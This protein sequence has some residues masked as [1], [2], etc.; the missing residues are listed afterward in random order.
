MGGLNH[1][2]SRVLNKVKPMEKFLVNTRETGVEIINTGCA[3]GVN[4]NLCVVFWR[5]KGKVGNY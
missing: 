3:R 2:S 5:E 1:R 4:N